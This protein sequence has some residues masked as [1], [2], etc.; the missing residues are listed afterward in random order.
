MAPSPSHSGNEVSQQRQHLGPV[1]GAAGLGASRQTLPAH[2]LCFQI[3]PWAAE[4]EGEGELEGRRLHPWGSGLGGA[5]GEGGHRPCGCVTRAQVRGDSQPPGG[6]NQVTA[7]ASLRAP[8]TASPLPSEL[9]H[10]AGRFL[11]LSLMRVPQ[12]LPCRLGRLSVLGG[13]GRPSLPAAETQ[14]GGELSSSTACS[15]HDQRPRGHLSPAPPA[16]PTPLTAG[17]ARPGCPRRVGST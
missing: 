17:E 7:Q 10:T 16:P 4:P 8:G 14:L 1:Q 6:W 3:R 2:K 5:E 12:R 9:K 13:P 11:T 15:G